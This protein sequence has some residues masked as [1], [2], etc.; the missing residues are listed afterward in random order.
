MSFTVVSE[1]KFNSISYILPLILMPVTEAEMV[2]WTFRGVLLLQQQLQLQLQLQLLQCNRAQLREQHQGHHCKE[3]SADGA[4]SASQ[5][6]IWIK[7][8][9][10]V[11]GTY[12]IEF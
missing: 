5:A 4:P 3:K 11:K 2:S 9:R 7:N 8:Y 10:K 1:A 6:A 12:G